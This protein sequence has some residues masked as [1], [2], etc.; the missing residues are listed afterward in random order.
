MI[1]QCYF[2]KEQE[3][4]IFKSELYTKFGL[5]PEV[6]ENLLTNCPELEEYKNRLALTEYGALLHIW[7]NN[8]HTFDNDWWIGFTSYRQLDK[9]PI[10]FHNKQ[11]FEKLLVES[12][13]FCGWGFYLLS[14][15]PSYQAEY[16]HPNINEFINDVFNALN[17][18]IPHRFYTDNFA[19]FANYWAMDKSKFVDFMSWSWPI[20]EKA[21][22][23]EDH[24]YAK[25]KAVISNTTNKKWLGY[26]MERL[27]ILWYMDRGFYP[28]NFGPICGY[29]T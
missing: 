2:K 28:S 24:K 12:G 15:N 19:L 17:L 5:E 23:M 4:Q 18:K 20:V 8:V 27:L 7:R 13:G 1:Y 14:K 29:L 9:T 16:C 21:L 25:T 10:V 6:N 26:F 22:T 11:L 3:N